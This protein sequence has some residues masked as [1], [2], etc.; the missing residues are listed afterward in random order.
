MCDEWCSESSEDVSAKFC[1]ATSCIMRSSMEMCDIWSLI[2]YALSGSRYEPNERGNCCRRLISPMKCL[3]K[4]RQTMNFLWVHRLVSVYCC[5]LGWVR[6]A[7]RN[8]ERD[9]AKFGIS[10]LVQ[11]MQPVINWI[12]SA[13]STRNKKNSFTSFVQQIPQRPEVSLLSVAKAHYNIQTR[14]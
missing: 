3:G 14:R 7:R 4:V 12:F 10:L 1:I 2:I 6:P 8:V 11:N 5:L 13:K 9:Q